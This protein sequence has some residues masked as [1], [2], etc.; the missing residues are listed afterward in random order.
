MAWGLWG[1]ATLRRVSGKLDAAIAAYRRS[2]DC[3]IEGENLDCLA[4][5]RA[6]QAEIIRHRREHAA[7]ARHHEQLLELFRGNSDAVGELWALQG[8]GQIHLVN[9]STKAEEFF[10]RAEDLALEIGDLRAI[11]FSRRALGMSARRRGDLPLAKSFLVEA[12]QIFESL[13]YTVGIG[14]AF[15]ELAHCEIVAGD[16]DE[17]EQH[18][19]EA[20][21]RFGDDFPLGRAWALATLAQVEKESGASSQL[22]LAGSARLFATLGVDIDLSLPQVLHARSLFLTGGGH[23]SCP[24]ANPKPGLDCSG[25]K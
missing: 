20:L 16:L 19:R 11:G 8:I 24:R 5:S 13:D 1:L 9:D 17:A 21:A 15:R 23:R 12:R 22:T 2:I 10:H 3:A 7:A 14:F 4:W 18:V 6:G 25:T